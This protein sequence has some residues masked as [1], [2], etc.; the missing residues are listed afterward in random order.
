MVV[1]NEELE[2]AVAEYEK[3]GAG[4][5]TQPAPSQQ[6]QEDTSKVDKEVCKV[7]NLGCISFISN[8]HIPAQYKLSFLF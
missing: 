6:S 8:A 2:A 5:T 1:K 3:K 7:D 4:D